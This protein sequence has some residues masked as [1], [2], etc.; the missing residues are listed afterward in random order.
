MGLK[1]IACSLMGHLSTNGLP[2]LRLAPNDFGRKVPPR[3]DA[4]HSVR[5][6][7]RQ[8]FGPFVNRLIADAYRF[9]SCGNS[10]PE[11]FNGLCFF[12]HGIEPQFNAEC[13][14]SETRG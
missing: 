7:P 3:N 5:D 9:G 14:Y 6:A 2:V 4:K 13:N 8:D 10:A 12:H 1:G 11:Q